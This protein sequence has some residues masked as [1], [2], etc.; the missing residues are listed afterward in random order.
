MILKN[1]TNQRAFAQFDFHSIGFYK[2]RIRNN[3]NTNILSFL[4]S[5]IMPLDQTKIL[6]LVVHGNDKNMILQELNKIYGGNK[7]EIYKL[8]PQKSTYEFTE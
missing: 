4:I 2:F 3:R 8:N 7:W 5:P 1:Q 6:T